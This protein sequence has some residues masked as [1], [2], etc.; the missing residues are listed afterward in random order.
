LEEDR[1]TLRRDLDLCP[2]MH[3]E[4]FKI[5]SRARLTFPSRKSISHMRRLGDQVGSLSTPRCHLWDNLAS[6][7]IFLL[8]ALL[9]LSLC[10]CKETNSITYKRASSR[11]VRG[12]NIFSFILHIWPPFCECSLEIVTFFLVLSWALSS[13]GSNPTYLE[14][15]EPC[16]S[17]SG[18]PSPTSPPP[19][20]L[21]SFYFIFPSIFFLFLW[22]FMV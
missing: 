10:S 12:L 2:H 13:S 20:S 19:S 22:C 9:S 18:M 7:T 6:T 16:A 4:S 15:C 17:S 21:S 8:F 11:L 14:F 5:A 1:A 3:G